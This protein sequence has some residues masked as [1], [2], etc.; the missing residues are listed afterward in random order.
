[1]S[2][3]MIWMDAGNEHGVRRLAQRLTAGRATGEHIRDQYLVR[4]AAI[5]GTYSLARF[6]HYIG[7]G[8]NQ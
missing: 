6:V 1:M 2:G 7:I 3:V 4:A 8:G 5:R